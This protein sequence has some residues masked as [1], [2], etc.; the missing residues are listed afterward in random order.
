MFVPSKTGVSVSPSPVEVL[1]SNPIGLRDQIPWGF[2]DPL[3]HP[4]A[5]KPDVG[6]RTFTTLGELLCYYCS[7]VCGHQLDVHGIW[8]YCDCTPLIISLRLLLVFGWGYL[9]LVGSSVLLSMVTQQLVE[10]LVFSQEEMNAHPSTPPSWNRW[11]LYS[12][13]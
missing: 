6:F 10:I 9:F 8:F 2:P 1:W 11:P 12:S 4:Q 7:P 3:S 13:L 5:W